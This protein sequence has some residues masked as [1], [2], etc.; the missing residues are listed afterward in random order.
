MAYK[1]LLVE[2]S[3]AVATVT[4]NRPEKR[5]AISGQMLTDFLRLFAELRTDLDTRFVIFTGAGTAFSAGADLSERVFTES[6]TPPPAM[7][8]LQQLTGHD[9]IRNLE[10][11]EQITIAAVNGYCLGAGLVL[12]MGCD[13]RIASEN[14]RFGV[15]EANIGLFFT[16]GSTPRLTRLIGPAKAKEMIMTCDPIDAHEAVRIGLANKVVPAEKLM[17]AVHELIDKIASKGPLAIRMTKK[18]VNAATAANF[19]DLYICES[20]LVERLIL[21]PEPMEG[22]KAFIEKRKPDFTG[23]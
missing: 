23:G 18:L 3:G 10:N 1:T 11:L 14:A 15:P 6:T 13:F 12:A 8:R 5:N 7:M 4:L 16:W 17:N 22:I 19:G 21:S 2:K 20:E 9:F